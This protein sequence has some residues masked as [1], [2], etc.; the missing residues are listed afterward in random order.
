MTPAPLHVVTVAVGPNVIVTA[1][2]RGGDPDSVRHSLVQDAAPWHVDPT[3]LAATLRDVAGAPALVLLVTVTGT[4][5]RVTT[6]AVCGP[7]GDGAWDVRDTVTAHHAA[8]A[9]FG[10]PA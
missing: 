2:M 5:D 8:V 10:G 1:G 7:L 4:A 3:G 6:T 9:A